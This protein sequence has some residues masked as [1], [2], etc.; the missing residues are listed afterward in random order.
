LVENCSA[1]KIVAGGPKIN[2][3]RKAEDTSTNKAMDIFDFLDRLEI[4]FCM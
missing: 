3:D 4:S 1:K 2:H